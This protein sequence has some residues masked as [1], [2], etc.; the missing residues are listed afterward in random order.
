MMSVINPNNIKPGARTKK[1]VGITPPSFHQF[2]ITNNSV[3]P[4]M[5][6]NTPNPTPRQS[7]PNHLAGASAFR[8]QVLAAA[9]SN[10]L[11]LNSLVI[12][13][14]WFLY[15]ALISASDSGSFK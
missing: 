7:A 6:I 14:R 1:C 15:A 11:F 5:I 8:A 4:P 2:N 13:Y 9:S 3:L 12:F 10:P